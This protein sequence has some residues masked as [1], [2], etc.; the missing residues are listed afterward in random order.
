MKR[1]SLERDVVERVESALRARL[2]GRF[3]VASD[4]ASASIEGLSA[5]STPDLVIYNPI[6]D[7]VTL[8]E[9]K[10]L[11][12]TS[13]LPMATLA[14]LRR[15]REANEHI[16][17]LIVLVTASRVGD[18]LRKKLEE[19]Q[20][21]LVEFSSESRLIAR[22]EKIATEAKGGKGAEGIRP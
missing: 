3:Q 10:G 22:L 11:S 16:A 7:S 20:F 1:Y 13:N 8:V 14:T 21:V 12:S 19:E 17:P 9:F 2:G 15:L 4:F 6:D 18:L 5:H